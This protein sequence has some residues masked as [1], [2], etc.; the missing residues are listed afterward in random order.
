MNLRWDD[1]LRELS[2]DQLVKLL[3]LRIEGRGF[4]PASYLAVVK[5]LE[6]RL[7]V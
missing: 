4:G 1:G 7:G 3:R 2:I 6:E 5:E